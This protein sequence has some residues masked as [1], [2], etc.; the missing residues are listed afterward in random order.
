MHEA[1]LSYR[2]HIDG[3]RAIAV[4]SVLVFHAFPEAFP[5]GF[6]GVDIFFVISGFLISG[7]L[8]AAFAQPGSKGIAVIGG[9]YSRRIRRIFPALLVVLAA[10]YLIGYETLL[11]IEL[12]KLSLATMA[13]AGFCL[14]IVLSQDTGYFG[15]DAATHPLLHLWSLGV[16]EQFYLV[17]PLVIWLATRIRA[18]LLP[19]TLFLGTCSLVWTLEK[20]K[21]VEAAAFFLP[22]HR[23]WELLIGAVAA[24]AV[25]RRG[26]VAQRPL[27][28]ENL[29]AIVGWVLVVAGFLRIR[30][31]SDIPNAWILLP[32]AGAAFV[33][34]SDG[35][36]W[37]HRRVLSTPL[38]VWIGLISYPLYLWHWPLLTFGR[39][40]LVGGDAPGMRVL[41]LALSILLAWLTYATVETPLR[42][43]RRSKTK[44]TFLATAMAALAALGFI[45]YRANGYP[46]R[47]PPLIQELSH[48]DYDPYASWREGTYFLTSRSVGVGFKN[49][50]NE[51]DPRKPS[52]VLWGDSHAAGLYPG[53][54]AVFGKKY[55]IVQRTI[56]GQ[57]PYL[58]LEPRSASA[59]FSLNQEVFETIQRIRPQ[60]VMLESN[61]VAFGWK[62]IETTVERLKA[63]GVGHIVLVGPVPQWNGSLL[64]QVCNYVRSHKSEPVPTRLTTGARSEPLEIDAS[65]RALS[66]RLGI[67]YVSPCDILHDKDGYLVRLGDAPESFISWDYGHLMAAGSGYLVSHFPALK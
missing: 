19:I 28:R 40:A 13:A 27:W 57:P 46:S 51:I 39:I 61:W 59:Q 52:L 16:E 49:D 7:I 31:A 21:S 45:I 15:T 30:S 25:F 66:T 23:L 34:S 9:F 17:W 67:Q 36:A 6:V 14:N 38:L 43:R 11:P 41:I 5:A 32:T 64:Q 50:P 20:P 35:R 29:Y 60:V 3:L 56:A 4:L 2:P 55:N 65:M 12:K 42:N 48:F 10:C 26:S 58:G 18:S 44:V 53:V 22:Q 33:V 1:K 24:L 54:Q 63:A 62:P 47:F 8:F 37:I